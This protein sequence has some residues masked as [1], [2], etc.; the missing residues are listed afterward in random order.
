MI[1]TALAV[2]L[3]AALTSC[4]QNDSSN[5]SSNP[6]VSS[7][8]TASTA[9]TVS[10][11][12][13]HARVHDPAN[14][15]IDCPLRKHGINPHEMKPFE[16]VEKYIAFLERADR[17][18]WQKPDAVVEGLELEGTETVADVGAGSGYFSFRFAEVLPNGKVVAIDIE[19]E[20]I[21]HIHHK[22]MTE[23]VNNVAVEIAKPHDPSVPKDADWVFICDVLHH[24]KD[25]AAWLSRMHEQTK[26]GAKVALI[27]FREGKLPE[28]PP[29]SLKIGKKRLV[30]LMT[31]AGFESIGEKKDIL[32]YQYMLLFQRP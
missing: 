27:E 6:P 19:P 1:R 12:E 3:P 31:D 10:S 24:V 14:P 23:G 13:P 9:P 21:R 32:P 28:G 11:H 29:E 20:M 22:A 2:V 25:R 26:S 5:K 7:T 16:D 15:P 8:T 17:A 4:K 18:A 30:E